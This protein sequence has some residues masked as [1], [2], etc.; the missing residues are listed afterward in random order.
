MVFGLKKVK[1]EITKILPI[2]LLNFQTTEKKPTKS[3]CT[4]LAAH[5]RNKQK[6]QV[7]RFP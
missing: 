3:S 7:S 2:H 5:L 4:K 6:K 1:K